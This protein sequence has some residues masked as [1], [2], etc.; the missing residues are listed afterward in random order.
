MAD[1]IPNVVVSM[2]SQLFTKPD[3]FSAV[4][5]GK[6]FIG[7]IDTDPTVVGN[8][9]QVYIQNED[10]SLTAVPQP[11]RTNAAGF[12]VYNGQIVKFVT[13]KGHSMT[14]QSSLGVQLFYYPNVLKYDPDQF[15]QELA[16]PG[17]NQGDALIAVV[18][19]YTGAAVRTQHQKNSEN[20]SVTDFVGADPTGSTLCDDAFHNAENASDVI[21]VPPGTYRISTPMTLSQ[22]KRYYG[23]GVLKFDNAEWWRRGGSSGDIAV[24][25]RYTLFYNFV[26][27]SDVSV[28]FDGVI[29]AITWID[30]RTVQ[31]PGSAITVSVKINIVNGFLNMGP[32]PECIRAYNLLGSA[33]AGNKLNPSLPNPTTAPLGY[34][35][36]AFGSRALLDM[37]SGVNNTAIGS[38]ALMSNQSGVNNTAVGFLALYRSTGNG[39]TAVGSVSGE[40]VT[41]GSYNSFFG[42]GS[43]EKVMTGSYNTGI[44]FE[45][46]AE[47]PATTYTVAVGYRAN[48][49][50]GNSSQSNSVY[51]GAFSGDFAIGSNNTMVGYRAGNCLDAG[52]GAG[53][54]HDNV[55]VGMFAM[56]KNLTGNENVV[57]GV[58]AATESTVVS[59]SVVIGYGAAGTT[60]AIGS[61]TVAIGW[62]AMPAVTGT[63]NVAIGQQAAN[64]ITTG[65]GNTAIGTSALVTNVTGSNNTAIGNVSGRLTQAG[66]ATTSLSNTTTIGNDAR[67]AASNEVQLGNS[68]TTTYVYGTVGNRSDVRD[69]A[70][71]V[72]TKLGIDFVLGLRPVS[73]KWN[74]RED[75]QETID[76]GDGTFT[77]TF[78]QEGYDAETKKRVR[79]HQWFIAQDVEALCEKLGVDFGGLQHK[80]KC[81]GDDVYTLGYDEFI[82]PITKAVQQCWSRLDELEARIKALE[83]K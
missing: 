63:N 60:T 12:P 76:N 14:V 54:A 59:S 68:T 72:E 46:L 52:E 50:T 67:V 43:G 29:Q 9:I 21:Y 31:A 44:G 64:T 58:G 45:A 32:T 35:N 81:G 40:W 83:S 73:G 77:T 55:G 1:P 70:D 2:P 79:D 3:T 74:M 82:P 11:L 75:Y 80:A 23:L 53:T 19:P 33:G 42:I 66:A 27:Q 17:I 48:G 15:K 38:K 5:N 62:N 34:D 41:T 56:R 4:S 39:N 61:F 20:I 26:N 47:A 6:I 10:D 22:T 24:P 7:L 71:V 37:T 49:N 25:E 65:A 16:G 36:T 51:V 8:Q 30:A 57:I 28:T 13:V 69:K 78:D 18:Q